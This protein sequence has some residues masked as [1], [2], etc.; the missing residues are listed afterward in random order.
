MNTVEEKKKM[1]MSFINMCG[2][3]LVVLAFISLFA[4]TT[5]VKD[6][7]VGITELANGTVLNTLLPSGTYFYNPFEKKIY[8]FRTYPGFIKHN[9]N[10]RFSNG[11]D[12]EVFITTWVS[13][14][15]S[16][17]TSLYSLCGTQC[18]YKL[19]IPEI[20]SVVSHMIRRHQLKHYSSVSD[21]ENFSTICEHEL[22]KRFAPLGIDVE[23]M[24]VERVILT[25]WGDREK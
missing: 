15:H 9:M 6:G 2:M 1:M 4:C 10:V 14:A 17:A 11:N 12:G 8:D 19:M 23:S 20:R 13:V 5:V 16:H 3:V 24:T 18:V 21:Y 25:F 22:T 7:N